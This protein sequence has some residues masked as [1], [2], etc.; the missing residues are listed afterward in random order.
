MTQLERNLIAYARTKLLRPRFT[1]Q[2]RSDVLE[3]LE[4]LV[5]VQLRRAG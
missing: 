4:L 2:D 1:H 3:A 5:L